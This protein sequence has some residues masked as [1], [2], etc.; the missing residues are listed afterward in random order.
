MRYFSYVVRVTGAENEK[1]PVVVPAD[2]AG[3]ASTTRAAA[4]T[5]SS[6]TFLTNHG[7]VLITVAT[8]P[9]IR[10]KEL[11]QIVGI[12]TRHALLILRDLEDAGYVHR[13]RVG[14]ATHYT[15]H[16]SRPFRHPTAAAH[17]VQE[18]IAIFTGPPNPHQ[19]AIEQDPEVP[20][21]P[22]REP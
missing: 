18:L 8:N 1:R 20:V 17:Q 15:V 4:A 5:T 11:A 2:E 12:T 3:L 16:S 6:W 22:T 9:D 7:H 13:Q 10:V 14:R 21:Q 19:P